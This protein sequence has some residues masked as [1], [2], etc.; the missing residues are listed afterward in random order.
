MSDKK[1]HWPIAV[2]FLAY[3]VWALYAIFYGERIPVN[4]GLGWDGKI[5]YFISQ[6]FFTYVQGRVFDSYYILRVVPPLIVKAAHW[7]TGTEHSYELTGTFF[8]LLNLSSMLG[9]TLLLLA[10]LH[11][12]VWQWRLMASVFALVSFGSLRHP[13]YYPIL[14]DAF[15]FLLGAAMLWAFLSKRR[16]VLLAVTLAG[17]FTTPVLLLMAF[18]LLAFQHGT[19]TGK[20]WTSTDRV[21]FGLLLASVTFLALI[22]PALNGTM[23]FGAYQPSKE[24][25][26]LALPFLLAY[27]GLLWWNMGIAGRLRATLS[28]IDRTG[29]MVWGMVLVAVVLCGLWARPSSFRTADFILGLVSNGLVHP[30]VFIVA[31]V[32]FIGPAFLLILLFPVRFRKT[33]AALPLP[34]FWTAM[35]ALMLAVNSESRT[36]MAGLPF[37]FYVLITALRDLPIHRFQMVMVIVLSLALS[38][39]WFPINAGEMTGDFLEFP[40]QRYFMHL[41]P[42]MNTTAYALQLAATVVSAGLLWLSFRERDQASLGRPEP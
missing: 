27:V 23:P 21:L 28:T 5:Y 15:A 37:I 41:G 39:V 40:M 42:W 16:A 12:T 32:V 1:G 8:G 6:D 30:A 25:V 10:C 26:L 22:G 13:Y 34:L 4:G 19:F 11:D 29:L 38:K 7:L 35:C 17:A 24:M 18:P 14:T 36:L 9:G 33:A 2:L 31:H 20:E 3:T